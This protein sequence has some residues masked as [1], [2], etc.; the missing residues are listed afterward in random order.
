MYQLGTGPLQ[1]FLGLRIQGVVRVS[2]ARARSRQTLPTLFGEEEE[3]AEVYLYAKNFR[4]Q[5]KARLLKD[6]IV[7]KIVRE[8]TLAPEDFKTSFGVL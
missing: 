1:K 7:T 8:T 5:L 2:Q 3:E 6:K 4:R